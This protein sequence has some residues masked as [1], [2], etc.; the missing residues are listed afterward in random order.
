MEK[1]IGK[2]RLSA[3][4]HDSFPA[5]NREGKPE[6]ASLFAWWVC[7]VVRFVVASLCSAGFMVGCA[8]GDLVPR[9][10]LEPARHVGGG[11]F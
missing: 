1:V 11:G 2:Q 9:A 10:G 3:L 8:P 5:P 4:V 6:K 7:M